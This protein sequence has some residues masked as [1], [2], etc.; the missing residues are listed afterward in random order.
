MGKSAARRYYYSPET[1]ELL[2]NLNATD[3]EFDAIDA[4]VAMLAKNPAL[5]YHIP[6]L[7]P[8]A[9]RSRKLYRYDVGRFGLIY[10]YSRDEL[11]IVTVA[12]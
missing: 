3:Q 10:T 7:I 9:D 11:E 4:Q 6:F 8:A 12:S 5:G 1:A 2:A